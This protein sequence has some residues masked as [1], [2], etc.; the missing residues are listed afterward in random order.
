[1]E[2]IPAYDIRREIEY[3]IS[4]LN[5]ADF[6][7]SR[8]ALYG[9]G[10]NAKRIIEILG[11]QIVGLIDSNCTGRVMHGKKVLSEDQ[12]LLLGI[13]TVI[14]AAEPDSAQIVYDREHLF[15]LEN[16]IRLLDMYGNEMYK[17]QQNRLRQNI[18]YGELTYEDLKEKANRADAIFV[19]KENCLCEGTS[20]IIR[21][22]ILKLLQEEEREGK[23]IIVCSYLQGND[24]KTKALL[25]DNGVFTATVFC[26]DDKDYTNYVSRILHSACDFFGTDKIYYIGSDSRSVNIPDIYG[27]NNNLIKSAVQIFNEYCKEWT[28]DLKIEHIDALNK[29]IPSSF[30]CNLNR[31]KILYETR[32][33][34][35]DNMFDVQADDTLSENNILFLTWT[36]PAFDRDAGSRT[37]DSYMKLF[38]ENGYGVILLA[39]DFI[40]TEPYVSEF[41][42]Q[43]V[44][45]LTGEFYK[46]NIWN[47]LYR[48]KDK[49]SYI[50]GNY[51]LCTRKY[52]DTFKAMG[53][54]VRYY[55]MDLHYL[56]LHREYE[57]SGDVFFE[58]QS[59]EF[60]EIEKYLI[61]NCDLVYYPSQDEVD[62]VKKEFYKEQVKILKIYMYKQDEIVSNY[63]A[64]KRRGIMFVGSFDHHPNLDA[65]QWYIADILPRIE[66][67][68][69]FNI[70][71]S[72]MPQE[73]KEFDD[74]RVIP[75][76]YMSDN[77]LCE[78]YRTIKMVVIPLRFGA[79]IK[80]K[81]I[82][83]FFHGVPVVSTTIGMEGIPRVQSTNMVADD[84]YD[85]AKKVNELY[86]QD[87]LL[88]IISREETEIIRNHYTREY[89]WRDIVQDFDVGKDK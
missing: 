58:K 81:V 63:D 74:E 44:I 46:R 45:V 48:N 29:G 73:I 5:K 65:V 87:E 7:N 83:A 22:D 11:S 54:P 47:W 9:T 79:G 33:E 60:Y 10:M 78:L 35:L 2:R 88:N 3:R 30:I 72:N 41:R 62:I 42:K 80:G 69:R 52:I 40:E 38:L 15:Y 16:H 55:G 21:Q 8:V 84:A 66:S 6:E 85:F 59:R 71:G 1:M 37:I 76:G 17:I 31:E 12:V 68:I 77:E 24:E 18:L 50:F 25:S 75:R 70:V 43:G 32:F 27:V 23:N 86:N 34:P 51:P 13:D 19:E 28:G 20:D 49:I 4:L 89:I 53:I 82:E 14:M 57:V 56:R 26:V 67:G 39:D 64:S 36:V 61:D